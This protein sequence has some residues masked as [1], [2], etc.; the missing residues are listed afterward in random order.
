MKR[1][2]LAVAALGEGALGLGLI[3]AP[4]AVAQ[5]LLSSEIS[6]VAIVI[7]RVTGIAICSLALACWP[8]QGTNRAALFAML[9]YSLLITL[10]LLY[11]GIR[12]NWVGPLLWPA[13]AAHAVLTLLL[14]RAW[15]QPQ[16][17]RAT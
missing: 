14:A 11:L 12:G 3:A 6:G 8:R 9:T 16:E 13:A 1:L 7:G 15:F 4:S 17:D 10:Y 5:L 2:L